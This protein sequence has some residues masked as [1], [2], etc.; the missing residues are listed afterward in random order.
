MDAKPMDGDNNL[1]L[2]IETHSPPTAGHAFDNSQGAKSTLF[3]TLSP[4]PPG[5]LA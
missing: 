2:S 3:D 5:L 1:N 4:V